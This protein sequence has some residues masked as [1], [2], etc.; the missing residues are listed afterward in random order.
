MTLVDTHAHLTAAE[1]DDDQEAVIE[2]ARQAGVE[3]IVVVGFDL[4][5]S[6]QAVALA[7][8]HRG[9]GA[10]IGIHPNDAQHLGAEEK[11]ALAKLAANPAVVAI[12]ETGLDFY[13]QRAPREKQLE[14]FRWHLDLASERGLPVIVHDRDAHDDTLSAL[15]EHAAGRRI[16]GVMH[17]FSGS[18][19]FLE[20]VLALGMYISLGGPLTYP[21]ARGPVEI[22][23]RV[24]LEALLLETD[25]PWLTPA[26]HRGKRNEPAY[27]QLVARRVAEVRGQPEAEVAAATSANARALFRMA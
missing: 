22:A 14:A 5:T 18:E 6:R 3:R 23:R 27:V 19:A 26:P 8:Q 2:R 7:E 10:A 12:G 15:K 16:R 24:P 17:C 11:T 21:N 9:L 13:R 25:C 1:F 4:P 20:E